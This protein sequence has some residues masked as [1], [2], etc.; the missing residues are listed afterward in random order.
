MN[1]QNKTA[2]IT[3]G[4]GALGSV[5][6]ARFFD[7]GARICVPTFANSQGSLPE[8]IVRSSEKCLLRKADL[9]KESDVKEFVSA[10]VEKFGTIDILANIAGGYAGGNAIADTPIGQ[11]ES[12]MDMNLKSAFLM[13]REVLKPMMAARAGRIVNIAAMPAFTSGAKKGAYA[14]S[15]RGVAALTEILADETKGTG[16]TVNAIAPSIILTEDNKRSMP[17]ADFEKWVPPDEIADLIL[18]LCS[19]HGRS[20]SGNVIKVFGGV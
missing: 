6:A 3:G 16:V 17:D 9:S 8:R 15:K 2:I 7:A 10:V 19:E 12:M 13:S 1:F 11:W 20:I 4:T 18:F 14:I 5:V